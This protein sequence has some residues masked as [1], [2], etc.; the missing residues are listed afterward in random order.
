MDGSIDLVV[1]SGCDLQS[2]FEIG[3]ALR[4]EKTIM[5]D[6]GVFRLGHQEWQRATVLAAVTFLGE[7]L[8]REPENARVA[9]LREG[10]LD[11]LDPLRR[12]R[13]QQRELATTTKSHRRTGD[14]R[15]GVDRRQRDLRVPAE[16]DRRSGTDRRSGRDRRKR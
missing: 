6:S 7:I 13:R 9:A 14:R 11:V 2:D 15:G 16:L 4:G 10:L 3:G 5:S 12:I 1:V 8:E